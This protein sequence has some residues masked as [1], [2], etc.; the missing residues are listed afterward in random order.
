MQGILTV[1]RLIMLHQPYRGCK[2]IAIV[3]VVSGCSALL[4]ASTTGDVAAKELSRIRFGLRETL[5][6]AEHESKMV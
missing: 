3:F 2:R 5:V 6:H 1:L 4:M